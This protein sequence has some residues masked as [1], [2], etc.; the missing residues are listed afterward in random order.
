[1]GFGGVSPHQALGLLATAVEKIDE[2]LNKQFGFFHRRKMASAWHLGPTP[3]VEETPAR[4]PALSL[5]SFGK[6]KSCWN[7]LVIW[8]GLVCRNAPLLISEETVH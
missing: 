6:H 3:H 2:D 8:C 1:M 5:R 4:S 7:R